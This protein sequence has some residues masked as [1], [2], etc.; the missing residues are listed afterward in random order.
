MEKSQV[1]LPVFRE[2][3]VILEPRGS[4]LGGLLSRKLERRVRIWEEFADN[5]VHLTRDTPRTVIHSRRQLSGC[6]DDIIFICEQCLKG[7][8][9]KKMIGEC[10]T[11]ASEE[12]FEDLVRGYQ[13]ELLEY[14]GASMVIR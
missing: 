7:E 2:V 6:R 5:C 1:Y 4:A 12:Y 14:Y 10:D 8:E 13:A 9:G 11:R 3:A